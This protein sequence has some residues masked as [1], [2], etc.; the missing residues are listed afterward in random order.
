MFCRLYFNEIWCNYLE[1]NDNYFVTGFHLNIDI[2]ILFGN[3]GESHI[4]VKCI[5]ISFWLYRNFGDYFPLPTFLSCHFNDQT[6]SNS[7]VVKLMHWPFD[8]KLLIR[9]ITNM[10]NTCFIF[11]YEISNH[12]RLWNFRRYTINRHEGTSSC[13]L[14]HVY[15]KISFFCVRKQIVY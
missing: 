6:T 8:S 12:R 3:F 1:V 10:K 14:T 7:W 5:K 13:C 11:H 9:S 15:I 4:K 2:S